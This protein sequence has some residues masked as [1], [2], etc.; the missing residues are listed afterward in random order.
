M[1]PPIPLTLRLLAIGASMIYLYGII[2]ALRR[3]RMD[4][5]QSVLWLLSGLLFLLVSAFPSLV[6]KLALFLG[7]VAPSNAAFI[8]WLLSL[9]ALIFYQSLTTSRHAAQIK[10]LTQELALRESEA[11]VK[12]RE[13]KE[14]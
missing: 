6:L 11:K 7:F 9:T 12:P 5:R 14:G 2:V 10:I 3:S 1:I 4:V 13:T 8:V